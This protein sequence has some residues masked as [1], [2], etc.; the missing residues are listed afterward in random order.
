MMMM[1][2]VVVLVEILNGLWRQT[3]IL[4]GNLKW[5]TLGWAASEFK[6]AKSLFP[7]IIRINRYSWDLLPSNQSEAKILHRSLKTIRHLTHCFISRHHLILITLNHFKFPIKNRAMLN[8]NML[9]RSL[10]KL[11][12]LTKDLPSSHTTAITSNTMTSNSR[13]YN[14]WSVKT[15]A[16]FSKSSREGYSYTERMDLIMPRH[17]TE[18]LTRS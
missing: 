16:T 4:R 6:I 2:K 17:W 18:W 3:E 5:V 13:W 8:K 12:F 9:N 15:E 7:Q 1:T 11:P 14:N 10:A